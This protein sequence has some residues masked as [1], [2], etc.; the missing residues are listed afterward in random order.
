MLGKWIYNQRTAKNA[1]K[2]SKERIE[3]LEQIGMSW[4]QASD[5]WELRYQRAKE[6]YEANGDLNI[7]AEYKTVEGFWLNKWLSN[8]RQAYN[9]ELKN[10][11]L[12]EEQ[13][14]KI[15]AIGMNWSSGSER[16]WEIRYSEAKSY[17]E[18]NGD[19]MPSAEYLTE[20]GFKLNLWIIRQRDGWEKEILTKQRYD[21]LTAIGMQWNAGTSWEDNYSYAA[22]YFAN[23]GNLDVLHSF[24]TE[25]G[26]RLGNWLSNQR[27][28]YNAGKL[29]DLIA[30]A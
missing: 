11:R 17:Y 9:G 23:N 18:K 27:T 6:Y 30:A 24:T 20:S 4:E 19:L 1:G 25:D 7:P 8:Q 26:M 3:L 2:L 15:E 5:P 28:L 21:L 13:T 29:S 12:T 14:R 16:S 22:A 10:Y